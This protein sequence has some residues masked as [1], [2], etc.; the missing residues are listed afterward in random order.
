MRTGIF[1]SVYPEALLGDR[2]GSMAKH[3]FTAV[4]FNLASIGLQ[5]LPEEIPE[6]AR[7]EILEAV[8]SHDISLSALAG[9]FNMI[10]PDLST[11]MDNLSRLLGLIEFA[12]YI[13]VEIVTIC[14][15]TRDSGSM[16]RH[17]PDNS[18]PEAWADLVE[19]LAP[20]LRAAEANGVVLGVEPEP[21][22]VISNAALAKRLIEEMASENLGIIADPANLAAGARE[23]AVGDVLDQAFDLLGDRIVLAHAKDLDE[24]GRFRPAGQG[25]VPWAQ[26]RELLRSAGFDGSVICHSLGVEDIPLAIDTL[27]DG[28]F[29]I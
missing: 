19:M 1:E 10:D 4:Q 9:T 8:N 26:F 12:P 17:H 13:G 29:P 23:V 11:R 25:I 28:G 24:H 14:T 27:R 18:T 6:T 21:A 20:A 3:G 5:T 7:T 2:F 16:W 15:G 22:N